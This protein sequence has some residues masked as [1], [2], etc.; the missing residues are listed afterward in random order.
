[1]VIT[2]FL[3]FY[4]LLPFFGLLKVCNASI[5]V[6]CHVVCVNWKGVFHIIFGAWKEV[7]TSENFAVE[8]RYS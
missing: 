5:V 7:W 8:M 4:S 2:D 3:S 1:V 6:Y